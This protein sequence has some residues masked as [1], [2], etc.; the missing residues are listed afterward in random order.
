MLDSDALNALARPRERSALALRARATLAV[1]H[2]QHALVRVPAPVLAEVCRGGPRD[3]PIDH[4]LSNRGIIVAPL[5]VNIARRAGANERRCSVQHA[6]E[7][8][9]AEPSSPRRRRR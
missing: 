6:A 9:N 7:R 1:A 4:V 3:A 8:S 2:E 5:T